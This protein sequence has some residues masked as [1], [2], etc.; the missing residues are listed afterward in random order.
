[1]R[2][3]LYGNVTSFVDMRPVEFSAGALPTDCVLLFTPGTPSF[4][5][6]TLASNECAAAVRRLD[7]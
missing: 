2:T 6:V 4:K 5:G 1:V 7:I 3:L